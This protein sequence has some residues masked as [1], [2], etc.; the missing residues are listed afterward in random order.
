MLKAA[1]TLL[2][3]A[4]L[5]AACSQGA[6]A[7]TVEDPIIRLPAVQGNPGVA[8][9]TLRS[10]HTPMR[11]LRV[12]SPQIQRI[13][14]HESEMVNGRMRMGPLEDNAFTTEG[15][16]VFEE[17]GAHAMLFGISPEVRA[18]GNVSLTFDVDDAPDVTVDV[19]VQSAGGTGGH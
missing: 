13:E 16:K 7:V 12:T 15:L 3:F 8:Y 5:L 9:F 14:L 4:A 1:A 11:I 17:G 2:P 19:P 18:G 10:N 6:P